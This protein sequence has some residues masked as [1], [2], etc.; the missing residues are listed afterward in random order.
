MYGEEDKDGIYKEG[1]LLTFALAVN[2]RITSHR[3]GNMRNYQRKCKYL[4]LP[5]LLGILIFY[6]VPFVRVVYYSLIE[7][8]FS[9]KW[10]GLE[11]YNTLFRNPYFRLAMKNS[12]LLILVGVPVL[13]A[14]AMLV[15]VLFLKLNKR[16]KRLRLAFILPMLL[17]TAGIILA[18][19]LVFAV[20][21]SPVPVYALFI[22][23]N[24]GIA[25]ILCSAAFSLLDGELYEAA[26]LDG[27]HGMKLH[28]Y[29]TLPLLAPTLFFVTLLGIVYSF[30]IFR[31]SYLYYGSNYPPDA[32]YSLQYYMN[33]HFMKLNYQ[34]LASGAVITTILICVIVAVGIRLQRR[35]E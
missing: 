31:E 3:R 19:R 29:V 13:V 21:E 1:K 4:L 23:K 15:S 6:A 20:G 28:W 25:V 22:W 5:S 16:L 14:G 18:W 8:Q 17:P 11:N 7:N 12:L 10:V 34:Y 35:F 24:I 32:G 9:K 26:K 27:A 30:R 2:A 33:N